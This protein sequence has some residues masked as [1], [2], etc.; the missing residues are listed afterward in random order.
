LSVPPAHRGNIVSFE[1]IDASGK[2]TQAKLLCDSFKKAGT[3]FGFLS[4]PE[5]TTPIGKEIHEYLH[6]K[7]EYSPETM[8]LLY[9][10]NRY[11]FKSEIERWISEKNVVVLNRYCESNIAYGVA[12]GLPRT[13]LEQLENRMPQSDY[14]FYLR[15]S[16]ELS[17]R[18][19]DSRDRFEADMKFL[20][21]VS[22]V[23]DALASSSPRWITIEGDR[24]PSI[25]HYEIMKSLSTRLNGERNTFN[26]QSTSNEHGRPSGGLASHA[27]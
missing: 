23:Y 19:K 16:P 4:F 20:N 25:I 8:H 21:R 3:G 2:N 10:A 9:S 14:V 24:N 1:G 11:E 22:E 12:D 5:Y 7:R 17:L 15:I 26:L 18:R 6:G 27:E 13:W